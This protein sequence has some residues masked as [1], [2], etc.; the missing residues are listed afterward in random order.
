MLISFWFKSLS[1]K[2]TEITMIHHL[3][4][5]PITFLLSIDQEHCCRSEIRLLQRYRLVV[6]SGKIIFSCIC[7]ISLLIRQSRVRWPGRFRQIPWD[8]IRASNH[9]NDATAFSSLFS[10]LIHNLY[11]I[12]ISFSLKA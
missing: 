1:M 8:I 2:I 7:V 5:Q 4:F 6:T 9:M 11:N 3:R 10:R 12:I